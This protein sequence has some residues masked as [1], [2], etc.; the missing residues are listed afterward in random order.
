MWDVVNLYDAKSQLH[1]LIDR[2]PAGKEDVVTYAEK[3]IAL[4]DDAPRQPGLL[5]GFVVPDAL[6]DP[7]PADEQRLWE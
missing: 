7:L 3:R 2:P 1:R 6:F 5:K 4:A